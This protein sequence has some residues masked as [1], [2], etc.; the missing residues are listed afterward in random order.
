MIDRYVSKRRTLL[1]QQG[2][3][4]VRVVVT[5]KLSVMRWAANST[6]GR[7]YLGFSIVSFEKEADAIMFRLWFKE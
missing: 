7:F 4:V 2:F 3:I 5:N 1:H 6:T